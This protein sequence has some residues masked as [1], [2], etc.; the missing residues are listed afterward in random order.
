MERGLLWSRNEGTAGQE[1]KSSNTWTSTLTTGQWQVAA[2]RIE[3]LLEGLKFTAGN[4]SNSEP[5][6]NSSLDRLN[7]I[8]S[9]ADNTKGRPISR[10]KCNDLSPY[11]F[12]QDIWCS[13]NYKIYKKGRKSN[14]LLSEKAVNRTGLEMTQLL[15]YKQELWNCDDFVQGSSRKVHE[16][17]G[18]FS[19][20]MGLY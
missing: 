5:T 10:H 16:R 8:H 15:H 6:C 2:R 14:T 7:L 4:L 18:D 11:W 17:T 12:T 3:E 1:E 9:W 20:E 13:R 19:G